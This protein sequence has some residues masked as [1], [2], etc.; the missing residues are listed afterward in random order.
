MEH[1]Y[2]KHYS[3]RLCSSRRWVLP[4]GHLQAKAGRYLVMAVS[5]EVYTNRF[6]CTTDQKIVRIC[7]KGRSQYTNIGKH[8]SARTQMQRALYHLD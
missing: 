2:T 3:Q 6:F 8:P 5:A 7:F 4:I 1:S